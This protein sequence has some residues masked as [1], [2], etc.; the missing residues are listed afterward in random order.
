LFRFN[1]GQGKAGSTT[2]PGFWDVGGLSV[3]PSSGH[4]NSGLSQ[5]TGGGTKTMRR[6]SSDDHGETPGHGAESKCTH[7]RGLR[8][9]QDQPQAIEVGHRTWWSASGFFK[10][11]RARY[12]MYYGGHPRSRNDPPPPPIHPWVNRSSSPWWKVTVELAELSRRPPIGWKNRGVRTHPAD[13]RQ[14][15]TANHSGDRDDNR[16][17]KSGVHS[18]GTR[19]CASRATAVVLTRARSEERARSRRLTGTCAG[20]SC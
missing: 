20:S 16:Q 4:T 14:T 5:A 7:L 12:K 6:R 17:G 3:T 2:S 13:A 15:S 19:T 8:E 10:A 9:H 11:R 1:G 18:T